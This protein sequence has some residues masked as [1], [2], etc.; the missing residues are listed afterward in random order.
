MSKDKTEN[1][2]NSTATM[3]TNQPA[4]KGPS[5]AWRDSPRFIPSGITA[6]GLNRTHIRKLEVYQAKALRLALR[7]FDI[8]KSTDLQASASDDVIEVCADFLSSC[9]VGQVVEGRP[10]HLKC[11]GNAGKRRILE[12]V[13]DNEIVAAIVIACEQADVW[14]IN[15]NRKKRKRS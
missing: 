10:A 12:E 7:K 13:A 2:P 11:R 5:N 4:K 15:L 9:L 3:E 8:E 14:S 1:K 6:E